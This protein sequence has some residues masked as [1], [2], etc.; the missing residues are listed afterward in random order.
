MRFLRYLKKPDSKTHSSS[1]KNAELQKIG[2]RKQKKWL[3]NIFSENFKY[4]TNLYF[5]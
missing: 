1:K 3:K 2:I 4:P 5:W